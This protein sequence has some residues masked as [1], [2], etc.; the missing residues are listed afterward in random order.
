MKNLDH[1][2]QPVAG[3]SHGFSESDIEKLRAYPILKELKPEFTHFLSV[4]HNTVRG[5][6]GNVSVD[7]KPG[8]QKDYPKLVYSADTM[9]FLWII[10][11]KTELRTSVCLDYDSEVADIDY[12]KRWFNPKK[13]F[14]PSYVTLGE[15]GIS[16]TSAD[17]AN[18]T[19]IMSMIM[20]V[21]GRAYERRENRRPLRQNSARQ[22]KSKEGSTQLPADK[23]FEE[24]TPEEFELLCCQKLRDMGWSAETTPRSGDQGVDVR[25]E[26]NGVVIAVQCKKYSSSTIGNNAVQEVIGGR[27][28]YDA[29]VAFVVT[30]MQY[31]DSAK[32]LAMKANIH[33]LHYSELNNIDN[34]LRGYLGK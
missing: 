7:V 29:D 1:F 16:I 32:N 31:T 21:I 26:K 15:A 6:A 23:R 18:G 19:D 8:P 14:S 24:A 10:I 33:L 27:T 9:Q 25:A 22:Q 28:F 12:A 20:P 13:K 2:F 17:I 11:H 30:N 3:N 4:V 34:I 5:I